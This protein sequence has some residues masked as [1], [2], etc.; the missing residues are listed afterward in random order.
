MTDP[1]LELSRVETD[2][3]VLPGI[4]DRVDPELLS[5]L[6]AAF[7][8]KE[9]FINRFELMRRD[10]MRAQD[11]TQAAALAF[12]GLLHVASNKYGVELNGR[13]ASLDIETGAI[14]KLKQ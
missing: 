2:L 10:L 7:W 1:T 11:E 12:E 13:D 3:P 8:K 14:T 6:Q 4:P 9:A 5:Q